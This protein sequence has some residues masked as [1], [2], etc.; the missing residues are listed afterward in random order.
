MNAKKEFSDKLLKAKNKTTVSEQFFNNI[1]YKI[2]L[3]KL[4]LHY[5][6]K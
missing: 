1:K 5:N 6:Q 4:K 2:E 3:K